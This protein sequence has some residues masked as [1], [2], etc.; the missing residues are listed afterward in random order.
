[1]SQEVGAGV[2][3]GE[4]TRAARLWASLPAFVRARDWD[5][6]VR[7]AWLAVSVA[8]NQPRDA[9]RALA[10]ISLE[11]EWARQALLD[12]QG[13]KPTPDAHGTSSTQLRHRAAATL[14]VASVSH[15]ETLRAAEGGERALYGARTRER[16]TTARTSRRCGGPASRWAHVSHAQ[17]TSSVGLGERRSR[18]WDSN[19]RPAVYETAALPLSYI[20][21][22]RM[23]PNG[24]YRPLRQKARAQQQPDRSK[25]RGVQRVTH[26]TNS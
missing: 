15:A 21:T 23:I 5:D 6:A 10:A 24:L 17:V 13:L 18:W 11:L 19:P 3:D 26:P 16:G 9:Q 8:D 22:F 14:R 25:A 20:G 1:M 2:A 4:Q 7:V 12:L